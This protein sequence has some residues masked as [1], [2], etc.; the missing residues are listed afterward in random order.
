MQAKG[1]EQNPEPSGD[2]D[3]IAGIIV[4][5]TSPLRG[6][7]TPE[8]RPFIRP[9]QP[10]TPEATMPNTPISIGSDR[11][12]LLDRRLIDELQD[13]RQVL[14]QPMRRN[15]AVRIDHP[16]KKAA[17]PTPYSSKTATAS[18]P[19]T[20]ASPTPTTTKPTEPAPPTPKAATASPGTNQSWA[21]STSKARRPT[22]WS[23]TIPI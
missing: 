14:H 6:G 16:W 10:P 12:L 23:S 8:Y 11:Q 4:V 19:G 1:F 21:S 2:R 18:A 17:S 20:A 9:K 3:S 7:L 13:A 22:T 5:P 15:A